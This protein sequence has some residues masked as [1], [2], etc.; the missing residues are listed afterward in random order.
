MIMTHDYY[1]Y[2][3]VTWNKSVCLFINYFLLIDLKVLFI[4]KSVFTY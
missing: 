1:I 2:L 3:I 4:R